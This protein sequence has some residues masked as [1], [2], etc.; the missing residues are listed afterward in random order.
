MAAAC[1]DIA[2]ETMINAP[3]GQGD[4]ATGASAFRAQGAFVHAPKIASSAV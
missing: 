2:A 3:R 1:K 4:P